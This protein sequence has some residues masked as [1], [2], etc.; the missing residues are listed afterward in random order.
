MQEMGSVVPRIRGAPR[1]PRWSEP[2]RQHPAPAWRRAREMRRIQV[3]CATDNAAAKQIPADSITGNNACRQACAAY[4]RARDAGC[5]PDRRMPRAAP[6][7]ALSPTHRR[8]SIRHGCRRRSRSVCGCC[9]H[10][11][12]TAPVSSLSEI[13]IVAGPQRVWN[14]PTYSG[15]PSRMTAS[16][17][18]TGP[19]HCPGFPARHRQCR[20]SCQPSCPDSAGACAPHVRPDRCHRPTR[21]AYGDSSLGVFGIDDAV[22]GSVT[23]YEDPALP[24]STTDQSLP[25]RRST[26]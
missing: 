20:R 14:S 23:Q 9:F 18:D 3:A 2:G 24:D 5:G 13:G 11:R 8:R 21:S 12:S 6:L 19:R 22:T 7:P 17:G 4:C 10:S 16:V 25:L 15:S 1:Y 26:R